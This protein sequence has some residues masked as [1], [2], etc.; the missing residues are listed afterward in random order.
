MES[1]SISSKGHGK[2]LTLLERL[3]Y[4]A[5]YGIPK[6]SDRDREI[7]FE[8]S[9]DE[10]ILV[11]KIKSIN[12]KITFILQIGYFKNKYRFFNIS[13][14]D[15]VVIKD[16]DYICKKYFNDKKHPEIILDK[17]SKSRQRETILK[18]F[19]Y[20]D[21][22]DNIDEI[23][24]K[25]DEMIE[26]DISP[27]YVFKE[28][29][30]YCIRHSIIFPSYVIM[31]SLISQ[32]MLKVEK[33][34]KN[35][36]T[37][38]LADELKHGLKDLLTKENEK[39]YI[40]TGLKAPPRSFNSSDVKEELD[41]MDILK[42]FFY[43]AKQQLSLLKISDASILYYAE[44]IE[45][46]N[47]FRIKQLVDW[48][49]YLYILCFIYIKYL[50][51]NDLLTT[52]FLHLVGKY[53]GEV[54][55]IVNEKILKLRIE[56][57]KNLKK[58]SNILELFTKDD[59][60]T[61]LFKD[62]KEKAFMFLEKE[63]IKKLIDYIR[64]MSLDIR[65]L[66]WDELDI[67]YNSI[68]R[69]I[70]PIIKAL[71]FSDEAS[72]KTD[73]YKAIR[74]LQNCLK[75]KKYSLKHAPKSFISKKDIK[76]IYPDNLKINNDISSSRTYFNRY[77]QLI[78]K[79]LKTKIEAG[80]I[81]IET[82]SEYK[83]LQDDLLSEE[84][85]SST[86]NII[87]KIVDLPWITEDF[88]CLIDNKLDN[89][90]KK[91]IS[92]NSNII[93]DKNN[94]F[95]TK[96]DKKSGKTNWT[97]EY[98]CVE[99]KVINNNIFDKIPNID[100][101]DLLRFVQTETTFLSAFSHIIPKYVKTTIDDTKILATTMCLGLNIDKYKMASISNVP[102]NVLRQTSSNFLRVDTLRKASETI[103][104]AVMKLPISQYYNI[105]DGVVHSSSDGQKVNVQG[106][107][108]NARY[109]PKYFG[110]EKGLS[111]LTLIAN[112]FSP[113]TKITS[114]NDYEGNHVLDLLQMNK[115]ELKPVKHSTDS[116]GVNA[117]N[118]ALL[119]LCGYMFAP[120]YK[121]LNHKDNII[122]S[123]KHPLEYNPDYII[124]P[125]KQINRDLILSE[126]KNIKRIIVSIMKKK[127]NVSTIVKKISQQ[128]KYNKTLKAIVEYDKIISSTYYLEYIDDAGLRQDVQ[129]ALNR[130]EAFHQL[131]NNVRF[132]NNGRIKVKSLREQ[133]IH[134]EATRLICN[135][136]IYYNS[137]IL[138]QYLLEK[139]RQGNMEQVKALKR[140][141]PIAWKHINLYGRYVFNRHNE[142]F[143]ISKLE[144]L[145][146]EELLIINSKIG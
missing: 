71:D 65:K 11:D 94:S 125:K 113:A 135:A 22:K 32:A 93:D 34:I 78:Y 48:K 3:E 24:R 145:M 42:P 29:Y 110:L 107:V 144:K 63:K 41:K 15:P 51:I 52:T 108:F 80:N 5:F 132:G 50:N 45:Q 141:S 120:R 138:N 20:R 8:L 74:F 68:K 37:K 72:Q 21:Y 102:Y 123:P 105:V 100:L 55:K 27:R 127:A 146:K 77:E 96:I 119:D 39:R 40:L 64:K 13:S 85:Y 118:F 136:I 73:F 70:R 87:A 140:V 126:E 134:H 114:P 88:K 97:L 44:L 19:S 1:S 16:I 56:N 35:K 47:I 58:S 31:Q 104:N 91:I 130:G 99:N 92:V 122:Y 106:K 30:C 17:S 143:V 38:S 131:Q 76:Y 75:N 57:S 90:E 26:I 116:H 86:Y 95:K 133:I 54:K 66:R 60:D 69:N 128:A 98:K 81:V 12:S 111:L 124:K 6:F 23:K 115:S 79:K 4:L 18:L 67:K 36:L 82:S 7:Y 142:L 84:E 33:I 137:Y 25:I 59:N 121:R 129:I 10:N 14:N 61:M 46:H 53:N 9:D 49:Q 112:H 62:I 43:K 83:S 101:F 2:R 117:V 28:V 109:S 139:L 89:L 103:I